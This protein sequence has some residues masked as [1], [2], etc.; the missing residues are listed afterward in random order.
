M[1]TVI[2]ILIILLVVAFL[3]TGKGAPII[4]LTLVPL[5]GALLAGFGADEIGRFYSEGLVKVMPVATMF[6]FAIM[7]FGVMQ[8]VGLFK[9]LIRTMLVLTHGNVI[10]VAIGTAVLGMVAHLD[11]A[12][13]TTF[14]LTIPALLPLYRKLR[15]SPYLMLMLLA[16]GAGIFNMTPWAGPMGRASAV[17]GIDVGALWRP[18]IPVQMI[19]VGLLLLFAAYLG[20]RETRRIAAGT[21]GDAA[22]GARTSTHHSISQ[23]DESL[24]KPRLIWVN[25]LIFVG[26]LASLF[27]SILPAAYI[28]MIGLSLALAINFPS[29]AAQADR[30]KA[31]APN[32]L[33]MSTVILAAGTFLGIMDGSGMLKAMAKDLVNILPEPIVPHLHLILGIFGLPMELILSTDA[34]YFGLLPIVQEVTS[35]YGVAPTAVVYALIIGNIIGTFI[36]PFSP[37]L[38]LALGLA[39]LE[40]GRHIRY[41]IL[42]MWGFSLVLL[43]ITILFGRIPFVM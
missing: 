29:L 36:S 33:M 16:T 11:G 28:F 35:A 25:C 22:D 6:I 31:H 23:E 30:I 3:L 27:T 37:A 12:G 41:S 40:I 17:T 15:M 4:G 34:Y 7:F 1:F 38:W 9:P 21:L 13:A 42:R 39:N 14:L 26:V 43:V 10:T 18:L 20:Q 8:D 2:G 5:I 32:A 19:G 24:L